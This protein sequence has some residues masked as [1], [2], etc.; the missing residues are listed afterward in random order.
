[1][2]EIIKCL[3][4]CL[5][6]SENHK[7][8]TNDVNI[9][10]LLQHLFLDHLLFLMEFGLAL[11]LVYLQINQFKIRFCDSLLLHKKHKCLSYSLHL[12]DNR[13][14]HNP[15]LQHEKSVPCFR[16]TEKL[17]F[18][19]HSSEYEMSDNDRRVNRNI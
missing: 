1:M 19:R 5:P 2:R 17:F 10:G 11:F 15:P 4:I 14:H 6:T 8:I 13:T 3:V 18:V 16:H 7:Q 9:P 12:Q